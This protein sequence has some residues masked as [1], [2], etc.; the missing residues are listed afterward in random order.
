MEINTKTTLDPSS[1]VCVQMNDIGRIIGGRA[2]PT[3]FIPILFVVDGNRKVL[4]SLS[5][6]IGAQTNTQMSVTGVSRGVNQAEL[7]HSQPILGRAAMMR[8]SDFY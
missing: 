1:Q 8:D 4:R 2:K 7:S 6:V 3:A 5:V